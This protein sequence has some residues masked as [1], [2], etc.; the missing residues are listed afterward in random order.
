MKPLNYPSEEMMNCL[1]PSSVTKG[2]MDLIA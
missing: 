2:M 1:M